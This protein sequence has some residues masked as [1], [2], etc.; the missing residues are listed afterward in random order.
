METKVIACNMIKDELLAAMGRAGA[1]HEILWIDE[2]LHARPE[3]LRAAIQEVLD[4]IRGCGRVLLAFG[5]CGG[6][7]EGLSAGDFELVMPDVDDCISLMLYPHSEGKEPGVY[8]LT[9]GWLRSGTNCWCDY[10]RMAARYGETKAKRIVDRMM[11][12]YHAMAFLENG[13]ESGPECRDRGRELAEWLNLE[14]CE[15]AGSVDWLER[16]VTGPWDGRFLRAG[17]YGTLH[18]PYG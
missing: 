17:P 14:Y 6:M 7:A 15:R 18:M 2:A 11:D 5:H 1:E 13:V 12:S 10:G 8:Y 16:L 3:K 9:G 4:G